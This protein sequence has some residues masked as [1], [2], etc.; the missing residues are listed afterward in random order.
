MSLRAH[1]KPTDGAW[2][3]TLRCIASPYVSYTRPIQKKTERHRK[4]P[5]RKGQHNYGSNQNIGARIAR[6][7][8]A[9]CS[10]VTIDLTGSYE[11]AYPVVASHEPIS[12][13]SNRP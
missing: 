10:A 6:R 5:C 13:I 8:C 4:A 12:V 11:L 2:S 7:V 1:C 3:N 9:T